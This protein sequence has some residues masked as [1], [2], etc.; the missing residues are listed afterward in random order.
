M[1]RVLHP[2][3]RSSKRIPEEHFEEAERLAELS[4]QL[5]AESAPPPPK[6]DA[7]ARRVLPYVLSLWAGTWTTAA[8]VMF[9]QIDNGAAVATGAVVLLVGLLIH[10]SAQDQT[11]L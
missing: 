2:P 4:R 8:L 6:P 5:E 11:E 1:S 9:S 10:A 3:L 7:W